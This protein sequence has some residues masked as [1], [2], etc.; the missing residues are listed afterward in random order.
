[1]QLGIFA[2]TFPGHDAAAILG[3]VKDAG[4][5]CTQFNLACLGLESMPT[6][7]PPE[8]VDAVAAAAESTG[9]R[10]VALSA[11]YNIIHP[12]PA[13]R[14]DGLHRLRAS[15]DTAR[16]LGI[17]LVTLC[18]GTRDPDDQWRHHP[19]NADPEAWFDLCRE[20]EPALAMAEAEGVNLGIEPEQA[21]VVR[22]VLDARR[23][24]DDMGSKRLRVVLDPANLFERATPDE[25]RHIVAEAV[26]LANGAIAMAHAKDRAADGRFVSV[27]AGVVDFPDFLARLAAEGF[28][29]PVV[30]HGLTATEAPAVSAFLGGLGLR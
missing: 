8:A 7:V 22:S 6:V 21:N 9:V 19:G 2:K 24:I 13:V 25:A 11:T 30:T 15:L 5:S 28:D 4:Y 14:R 26:A 27:G 17:P 23:L 10:L 12:D 20:M 16:L 18:T 1:M 3:A 29:G